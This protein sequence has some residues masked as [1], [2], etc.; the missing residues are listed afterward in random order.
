[1]L[2]ITKHR[3]PK[4][5]ENEATWHWSQPASVLARHMSPVV[6]W[7]PYIQFWTTLDHLFLPKDHQMTN[8]DQTIWEMNYFLVWILIQSQTDR[9]KVMHISPRFISTWC[10]HFLKNIAKRK[11]HPIWCFPDNCFKHVQLLYIWY[12]YEY[13]LMHNNNSFPKVL[14]TEAHVYDVSFCCVL[15]YFTLF[16]LPTSWKYFCYQHV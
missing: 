6:F 7:T 4:P 2:S 16:L 5:D 15:I 14:I 11:W 1:M 10:L 12:M 8:W 13:H 3:G 9:Q